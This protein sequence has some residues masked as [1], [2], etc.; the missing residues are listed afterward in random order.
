MGKV[1]EKV[2]PFSEIARVRHPIQS[3]TVV[4]VGVHFSH[5][6]VAGLPNH[7]TCTRFDERHAL[8]PHIH[9]GRLFEL[10]LADL[11][12][13]QRLHQAGLIPPEL[14]FPNPGY[15]RPCLGIRLPAGRFLRSGL[16]WEKASRSQ[17]ERPPC[18]AVLHTPTAYRRYYG[19]RSVLTTST[20]PHS[21][22][23]S[24]LP[25]V[26]HHQPIE[27]HLVARE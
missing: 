27:R 9:S 19:T 18:A 17:S 4:N 26:T 6:P 3:A 14:V 1:F 16:L 13:P 10:I 5:A 2:P 15:L 22:N 7:P 12:G 20:P 21:T 25:H 23:Q 11:Y 24:T 8:G